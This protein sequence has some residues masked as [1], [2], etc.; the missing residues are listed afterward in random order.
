MAQLFIPILLGSAR[1]GRESEK[2]AK[3][4]LEEARKYGKFDTEFIDVRD[5][6]GEN[7]RTAAM[8]QEK[9]KKWSEI[10]RRADGLIVVSPEYNHGYPGEL[11]LMLDEIY[12]EYNRKPLAICGVSIGALG[13]AR[14]VEVLRTA[15]IELQMVPVRS[16][17]YFSNIRDLFNNKGEIQDESLIERLK[18]L[19]E[20]LSWY[21]EALKKAREKQ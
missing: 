21:A 20:E 11:K 14:M 15:A 1:E 4:V 13:G 5:Y 18:T 8:P 19:F 3:F 9:S 10:M 7:C 2:A 12:E 16:A 17:V 6:V